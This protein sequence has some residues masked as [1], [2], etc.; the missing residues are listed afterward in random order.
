MGILADDKLI[1]GKNYVYI[2]FPPTSSWEIIENL[3]I[4]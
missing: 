4:I 1:K 3:K 2:L